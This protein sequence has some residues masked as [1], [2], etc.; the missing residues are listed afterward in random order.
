VL[1]PVPLEQVPVSPQDAPIGSESTVDCAFPVRG[2]DLPLEPV[3]GPSELPVEPPALPGVPTGL[4]APKTVAGIGLAAPPDGCEAYDPNNPP[5]DPENPP[6]A[7]TYSETTSADTLG[8]EGGY[9]IGEADA[10]LEN[11]PDANSFYSVGFDDEQAVFIDEITTDDG[12]KQ[13]I[14][15]A[16]NAWSRDTSNVQGGSGLM[17]TIQ[18]GSTS[19]TTG[20]AIACD[21]DGCELD[22]RGDMGTTDQLPPVYVGEEDSDSAVARNIDAAGGAIEDAAGE[23]PVDEIIGGVPDPIN[24]GD[25]VEELMG[26]MGS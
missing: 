6:G 25:T 3:P 26:L 11:G 2:N 10:G 4:L 14:V 5:V 1:G 12:Q 15:E 7:P 23:V 9:K 16:R 22:V 8:P 19:A 21:G 24:P 18:S 13:Y 20:G 17:L